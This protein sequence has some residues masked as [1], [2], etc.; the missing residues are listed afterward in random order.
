MP[1]LG[2]FG[3]HAVTIEVNNTCNMACSFCPLPI[4]ESPTGSMN[5][6]NVLNFLDEL[7][8]YKKLKWVQFYMYGEPLLN[9]DVWEYVDHCRELGL[10]SWLSTN[11]LLFNKKN[12][13]FLLKHPPDLFRIS[14]QIL[15]PGKHH[16]VR[17]TK[18]SHS[19]FINQ[20]AEGL[21]TLVDEKPKIGEI[22]TDVA[23]KVDNYK[24][25]KKIKHDLGI[26]LGVKEDGDPTVNQTIK[27]SKVFFIDFLKLVEKKSSTFKLSLEQVDQ[28]I[29][30]FYSKNGPQIYCT[31]YDFGNNNKVVYKE[32]FNGRYLTDY[33]PVQ[34]G[35]CSTQGVG[36]LYDGSVVLCVMD[37][38]GHSV[39][40]NVFE[41]SLISIL[42]RNESFISQLR[43]YG[44]M[45]TEMCKNCIG[46]PTKHGALISSSLKEL[47][48]ITNAFAT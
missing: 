37:Y 23:I 44:P 48:R 41:E 7:A 18:M 10:T 28:H 31:A 26:F 9:K 46:A 47:R 32:F 8:T 38:Q 16:D 22:R 2:E 43:N 15:D 24:G 3:Y 19:R 33:Y 39:M 12:V 35:S 11:G 13:D 1:D 21:A 17:G 40:G 27:G 34:R 45:P 30:E 29:E 14:L 6:K 20:V 4:R 5:K 25:L 42:R 36:I